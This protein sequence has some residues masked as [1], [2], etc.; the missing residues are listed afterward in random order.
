M[1]TGRIQFIGRR[2]AASPISGCNSEAVNW[3][4]KVMIP[5]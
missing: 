2:S 3:K 1:P 5:T 4:T